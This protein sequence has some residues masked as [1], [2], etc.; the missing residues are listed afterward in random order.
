MLDFQLFRIKVFPSAQ[1]TLFESDKTPQQIL[2]ET[3]RSLPETR[4]RQGLVWHIG[5]VTDVD[6]SSIYFRVGRTSKSTVE[7]YHDGRFIDEEFET[8][9]YT[10]VLLETQIEVCAIAR[11]SKLADTTSGIARQ[12]ARLL[13]RSDS[14]RAIRARF[15]VSMINDPEGFISRLRDAVSVETF[16]MTFTK[17]NAIDVDEDFI[18]P[19]E[20]LLSEA[21]GNRGKTQIQGKRMAVDVLEQL[22]RSAASTGDNAGASVRQDENQPS[23]RISLRGNAVDLAQDSVDTDE[24]KLTLLQR[25]RDKYEEIREGLSKGK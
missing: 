3:I 7:V 19:A 6:E 16:W 23:I 11:K 15:E 18:K 13:N 20:R 21:D 25:L 1:S 24:E 10:H 14:A 2:V 5:N 17:P 8:S 4:S 12:L 9:P 22:S